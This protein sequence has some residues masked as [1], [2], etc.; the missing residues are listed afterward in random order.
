MKIR[1]SMEMKVQFY[2]KYRRKICVN[3]T[4]ALSSDKIIKY[5]YLIHCVLSE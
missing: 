3:N 2:C 1:D 4:V 5:S